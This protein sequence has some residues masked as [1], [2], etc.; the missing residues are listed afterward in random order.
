[1]T[2]DMVFAMLKTAGVTRAEVN[3]EGGNDEGT[4]ESIVLHKKDG[5]QTTID[6][7][8]SHSN[9]LHEQLSQPVWDKYGSFAGDFDVHGVVT[10]DVET[11]AIS[12]SGE[13]STRRCESFDE[14]VD[15]F[16]LTDADNLLKALDEAKKL[17][18]D[19]Q[20]LINH[21]NKAKGAR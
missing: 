4:I 11:G 5:T 20:D 6:Y 15:Q 14:E 19:G 8:Y 17:K 18:L 1:M 2:R 21:I 10:W 3:F 12:I 7:S 9:P 13:E 16:D